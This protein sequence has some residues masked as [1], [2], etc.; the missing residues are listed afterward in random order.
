V[1]QAPLDPPHSKFLVVAVKHGLGQIVDVMQEEVLGLSYEAFAA[2][3]AQIGAEDAKVGMKLEKLHREKTREWIE[4]IK[5]TVQSGVYKCETVGCSSVTFS[6]VNY[7]L[8]FS[9]RQPC[10][11]C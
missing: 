4:R 10:R 7:C 6:C 2:F 3:V 1:K 5:Q 8:V 9:Q 11:T